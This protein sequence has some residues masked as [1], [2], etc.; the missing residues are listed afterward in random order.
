MSRIKQYAV[1]TEPSVELLCKATAQLI[2]QG[3]LPTGGVATYVEQTGK[4]PSTIKKT[5]FCQ[6]LILPFRPED[7]YGSVIASVNG[8]TH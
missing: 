8:S 1:A 3:Y 6:A 7:A 2:G 5:M 4:G